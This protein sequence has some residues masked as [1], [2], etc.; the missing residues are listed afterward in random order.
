VQVNGGGYLA[1]E[2]EGGG[3]ETGGTSP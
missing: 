2:G 3:I 1:P